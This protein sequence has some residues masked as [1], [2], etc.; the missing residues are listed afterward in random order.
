MLEEILRMDRGHQWSSPWVSIRATSLNICTGPAWLEKE[1][2]DDVCKW[3]QDMDSNIE[4]RIWIDFVTG[5]INGC[6]SSVQRT[7]K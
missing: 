5:W 6:W 2:Y 7:V 1:Q 3:H 4:C